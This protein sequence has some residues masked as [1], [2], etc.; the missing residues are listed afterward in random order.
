MRSAKAIPG[1]LL[2]LLL[3]SLH[4]VA[5]PL[6]PAINTNNIL[7]ILAYGAVSSSTLTNTAAIQNA[8]NA[9]ATGGTTNGLSGGTV[10]IPAG[11]YLSGPLTFKS[12]V[13]LQL[14]SGATLQMLPKTGWPGISTPFILG[15]SLSDVEISGTGMINGQGAGWWGSSPR[16]NFIQFDKTVR[17]L[18]QDVTLQ[19]P[20]TFHLYLK[21]G[22][23]NVTIQRINIDT[24]PTSPNTD[25]MDIGSTSMLIQDCHISDGDDNI[26]LGGSSY[27]TADITITNCLFGSGHG[28]SVGSDTGAGVSNVTVIN[29]VFTN[30]DNGI[31]MKSDNDRGGVVQNL[32]YCNI[33]MTNINYAPILIYSYYDS[34]G[35]PTASD[36]TP[37]TAAGMVVAAVSSSTPVWRNIVI[38]NVTATA[39]QP[40]MIWSRTE[41]P[42][43]NIILD[44][45]NVTSTDSAAGD[46]SFALYNVSGVQVLDSQINVAGSG[47]TF[48]LFDAGV[49]FSN[50]ATGANVISLDGLSVTNALSFYNQSASLSDGGF[51]GANDISLSGSKIAEGTSLSLD[52]STPV[53]FSLGTNTAWISVAGNLAINSSLNISGGAGFAAGTFT[54]FSYSGSFSGAPV[55][56]SIP[57][58]FNCALDT[59]AAG[60]VRLLVSSTAPPAPANLT[61]FGTN[62]QINLSWDAVDG[63][64]SYNLYRG[65]ADGGPYPTVIDG[66]VVTNYLDADVTAE[67]TYFYVVTAVA[68]GIESTNSSQ[69]SAVPLP[70]N[71][72]T[73]IKA[74]AGGGSLQLAWPQDHLG[75]SLEIQT[76]ALTAGLG[77][78]WFVVPGSAASNQI[79][80]PIDPANAAVFLRLVGP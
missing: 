15:S 51:F 13:N 12:K 56:G 48:E 50:A 24:V 32:S 5:V 27:T 53:N 28:V 42:A 14:D 36:I 33:T 44:R 35:N 30:T 77:S 41:L 22:D 17:I 74:Q 54:L 67:T 59:S 63:A 2:V 52:S 19:N 72:T 62:L 1:V 55:L 70:S 65:T 16:P 80:L 38:S 66:L 8:I 69:A 9:A 40:G 21:N 3:G 25:G 39:A 43:T 29:C 45:L 34:K 75:W 64:A 57:G 71:L 60:L 73:T 46:G 4:S 49:T 78:N 6:L 79:S 68:L 20:P 26:E 23:A 47:K 10:E 11:T 31:R 37:A 7:N 61:A 18:I 58:G 76:N